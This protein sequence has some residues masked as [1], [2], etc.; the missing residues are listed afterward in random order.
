MG[1]TDQYYGAS[2]AGLG[3]LIQDFGLCNLQ[4]EYL[5]TAK[6]RTKGVLVVTFFGQNS[7][8]STRG[9]QAVQQWVDTL[10]TGKWVAL[11]VG[12][13][14]RDELTA[15]QASNGLDGLT[16]LIDHELYQTRRWGV[17]HLPMTYVIA[18]KTGRVLAKVIGDDPAALEA[19][20][21]TLSAELDALAAAEA[22]AKKADDEKKAADAAAKAEADAKAAEAAK[23]AEAAGVAKTS[24]PRPAD[25]ARA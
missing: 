1:L 8:P 5:Y 17:S 21:N 16:F 7:G 4:G 2:T 15:F 9:L 3:K 23:S 18:G 22:A 19:A 13:G 20:K 10:P 12:E 24:E 25:A 6:A 14:G 11:A